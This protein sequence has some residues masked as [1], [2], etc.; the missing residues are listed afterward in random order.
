MTTANK[1]T[2]KHGQPKKKIDDDV[3]P[4]TVSGAAR[5]PPPTLSR[6][7]LAKFT[8]PAVLSLVGCL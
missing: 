4:S 1:Q 5:H 8:I 6:R 3:P 7:L 2:N